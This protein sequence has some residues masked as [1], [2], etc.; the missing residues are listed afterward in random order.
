MVSTIE[1]VCFVF[2]GGRQKNFYILCLRTFIDDNC[3]CAGVYIHIYIYIAQTIGNSNAVCFS[4]FSIYFS[5][6]PDKPSPF[7]S[8]DWLTFP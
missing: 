7:C 6:N 3:Q 2:D 8:V 4:L 1:V 5:N